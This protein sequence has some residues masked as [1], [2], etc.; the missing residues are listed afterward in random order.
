VLGIQGAEHEETAPAA[1]QLV[2]SKLV[3]SLAGRT[4]VVKITPGT[5]THRVYGRTTATEQFA[6]NYGLNPDY[7]EKIIQAGLI[8]AGM[9]SAEEVTVVE[10]YKHRFFIATLFMPQLSSSPDDPHPLIVA[11]LK[12]AQD[13][14]AFRQRSEVKL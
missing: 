7:R 1:S 2:V 13:L 11:F 9:D 8:I 3:C 4:E 14:Q 5:L 10:L 12:A 6:C